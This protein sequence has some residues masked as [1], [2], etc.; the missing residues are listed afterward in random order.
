MSL[1]SRLTE[2]AQPKKGPRGGWTPVIRALTT[3]VESGALDNR[4][5]YGPMHKNATKA[6]SALGFVPIA[7]R[8][9]Q[10]MEGWRW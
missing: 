1:H 5:R 2:A 3:I 7:E 10:H 6:L 4:S 8:T 9:E